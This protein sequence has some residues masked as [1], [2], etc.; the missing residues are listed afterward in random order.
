MLRC[1]LAVAVAAATL[2]P[3]AAQPAKPF[4]VRWF[5]QSYF[6]IET[7]G[8][9]KVVID[10]HQIPAFGRPVVA[11]DVILVTHNHDDHNAVEAVEGNKSARV[12]RGLKENKGR[13][14]WEKID[15]KVGAIRVRSL[16]SYHDNENGLSRGKNTIFLIQADGLT[17]CH[18]GDLGHELNDEQ[19]K[20][21][22]KVDVLM[23]PIGGTYTINGEQAKA[24]VAK[25]KPRLY[26]LPMHYG[27]PNY[28]DLNGP[29][30]FL[31][32]QPLA[33]KKVLATNELTLP[34]DAKADA[35]TVLL[36]A[37]AELKKK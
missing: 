22:G 36:L 31:D 32:K 13:V 25:L 12:F 5:G 1:L 3:A 16:A 11:A 8:G 14:E 27:L 18:L 29:E 9:K 15:E 26:V 34:P 20:Q 6:Q 33:V 19:V 7:P 21:I 10:P 2:S 23:V 28:D 4:K 37:P 24:V 35:P 17:F 30:E